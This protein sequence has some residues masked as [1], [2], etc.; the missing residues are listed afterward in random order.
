MCYCRRY[1]GLGSNPS[2]AYENWAE[3]TSGKTY[4]T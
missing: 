4:Y 3:A 1:T 2:V